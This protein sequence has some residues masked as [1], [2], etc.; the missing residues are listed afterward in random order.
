MADTID[1]PNV[2][3]WLGLL[4][5]ED[6]DIIGVH[7]WTTRNSPN[8]PWNGNLAMPT[9][10]Y[11]MRSAKGQ[12]LILHSYATNSTHW[13]VYA[14]AFTGKR[15]LRRHGFDVIGD[16]ERGISL[17]GPDGLNGLREFLG[18]EKV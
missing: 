1:R 16:K 13:T 17:E 9:V 10:I 2:L 6:W 7:G 14:T 5:S 12:D 11:H 15:E 18:M 3:S 8:A 4:T